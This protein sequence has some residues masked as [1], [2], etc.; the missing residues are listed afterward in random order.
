M[1]LIQ[2]NKKHLQMGQGDQRGQLLHL[3]QEDPEDK[4]TINI[5]FLKVRE[6]FR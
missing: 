3:Y 2:Q 4:M 1:Q 6:V 5:D